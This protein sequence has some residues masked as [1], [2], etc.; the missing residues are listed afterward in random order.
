MALH[1]TLG[2]WAIPMVISIIGT[3]LSLSWAGR[4]GGGAYDVFS[5]FILLT[6]LSLSWGIPWGLYGI[7]CAIFG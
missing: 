1:V 5:P 3:F 6:F 2:W 4:N 7:I